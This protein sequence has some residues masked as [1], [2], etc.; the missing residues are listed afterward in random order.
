VFLWCASAFAAPAVRE[1]PALP[2]LA[3]LGRS[4]GL[5][6]GRGAPLGIAPLV[7]WDVD[8]VV[9]LLEG[10]GLDSSRAR[11]GVDAYRVVYRTIGTDGS[12]TI[13]S[14]LVALPRLDAEQERVKQVVWLHGTTVY[15]DDAASVYEDSEDRAV[16]FA[17]AA[18]GYLTTA[19]DYLG[20]GL[21]SGVHPH[22][23]LSS[24]VSAAIDALRAARMLAAWMGQRVDPDVAVSGFGQ[25][26]AA[27]MALARVLQERADPHL[28][29][30]AL[31]SIAGPYDMSGTLI[32][33][34]AGETDNAVPTLAALTV[35]WNR[36][37]NLYDAPAHAFL[38]PYDQLTEELF[39]GEHTPE[40]VVN[41]LPKRADELFTP[42]FLQR[43]THPSGALRAALAASD[44]VCELTPGVVTHLYAASGDRTVLF[45]NSEMC[46]ASLEARG[47]RVELHDLGDLDHADSLAP[48]VGQVIELLSRRSGD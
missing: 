28:R 40:E 17:F 21:G 13:A 26:G 30:G 22:S 46:Q 14:S 32:D 10:F 27:S 9:D 37:Y 2:A 18:A 23:D 47:A 1:T 8:R 15:K 24:E 43:L 20:L 4:E 38:S 25:G 5:L 42:S 31:A 41:F 3:A 35:S 39:D 19:P 33:A 44:S 6:D 7:H 12:P 11:F 48:A 34:L 16:A 29:L 36:L 45:A